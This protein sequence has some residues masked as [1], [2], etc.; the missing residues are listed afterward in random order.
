MHQIRYLCIK[1][2][3]LLPTYYLICLILGLIFICNVDSGHF[4]PT[5]LGVNDYLNFK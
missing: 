3:C 2:V 5:Y 1:F 4:V